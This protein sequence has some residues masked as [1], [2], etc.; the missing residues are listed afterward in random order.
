M[1]WRTA[2]LLVVIL[3]A[4][5]AVILEV[6]DTGRSMPVRKDVDF[7]DPVRDVMN[8]DDRELRELADRERV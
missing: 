6:A 8:A 5:F 7:D 3:V 4:L 1:D 2:A